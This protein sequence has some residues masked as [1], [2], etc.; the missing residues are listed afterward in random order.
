MNN[1]RSVPVRFTVVYISIAQAHAHRPLAVHHIIHMASSIQRW[2]TTTTAVLN[3][4]VVLLVLISIIIG[5]P[6]VAAAEE[7]CAAAADAA[8]SIKVRLATCVDN[9]FEFA[10]YPRNPAPAR[11]EQQR[12][13]RCIHG[14]MVKAYPRRGPPF[15]E[16]RH[17]DVKRAPATA[18]T[19]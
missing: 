5:H 1:G 12:A 9:C 6:A 3:V 11:L 2:P 18:S 7:G 17:Q 8:C 4:V 15:H 19:S 16:L 14:C 13:G 10:R